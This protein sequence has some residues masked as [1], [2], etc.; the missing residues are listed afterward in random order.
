MN[1]KAQIY[2]ITG[3]S[4]AGKTTLINA[5]SERNYPIIEESGR[6]IVQQ[7]LNNDGDVLPWKDGIAFGRRLVEHTLKALNNTRHSG[8]IFSDRGLVDNIA[9]F[10]ALETQPPRALTDALARCP[11]HEPIFVMHPWKEIYA[12]DQIRNKRFDQA[13]R[14][15]DDIMQ[16]LNI[17]GWPYIE[18]PQLSVHERVAFI[19]SYIE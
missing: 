4:G 1:N 12:Q 2:L 14:E 11:Y 6:I 3:A 10:A 5:L 16:Q 13:L 18:V 7:E 8:P 19:E 9:W 17:L 15:F